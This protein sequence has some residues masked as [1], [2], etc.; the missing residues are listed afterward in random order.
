MNKITISIVILFLLGCDIYAQ[1]S[2]SSM[3]KAQPIPDRTVSYTISSPGVSKPIIWGLDLAWL[4]ETNIRRGIAF[5]GLNRVDVVRSSFMPTNPLLNGNTLQGD[6]LTNTTKRID[7]IKKYLGANASVVLNSDHPSVSSYF[8]GNATNWAK[9]IEVTAKLHEAEGMT[10]KT[11]SPFNEPDYSATGQGS[12]GDFYNICGQLRLNPYFNTIRISG[13]NT[14]N[15]DAAFNWYDSLKDRLDEGNTHQL[16]GSFNNYASF[17]QSV[18]SNN[19]HATND[20][21]HNVM[22]AMVGVEYGMQTGIWWGTAELARGEF[23]KASDGVRLGYAEHRPNWSAASVYKNL[24]GK[25]QLFGGTSERQAVTTTYRFVSKERDVYYDGYGP[26]REYTMVLPGGT[27]YQQGQTNAERMVNVSWGEDIQP[28]IDGQYVIVNRNSGKVLEVAGGSTASGANIQQGSYS[29]SNYQKWNVTPVSSRVGGDFSYFNVK[30]VNS[31]KSLDDLN[32]SLDDGGRLIQWDNSDS[33][34]QQRYLE[35]AN[36]G[37]FYIRSRHSAKCLD[38]FESSTADGANVVQW[39][40]NNGANQQWRLIPVGAAVEFVAPNAPTALVASANAESVRLDWATNTE[41]DLAG[42]TIFRAESVAGPY[43]TIA[44]NITSNSFVDN[45]T[46]IAGNY[47]Y[48]IKAVDKSLNSSGFSN[49]VSAV[50]TGVKDLVS[51]YQFDGNTADKSAN[52]N[53]SALFG[54]AVYADDLFGTK[55]IKLDGSTNFIQLPATLANQQE[56]TIATWVKWTGGASWQR[57][58]DFG[59]DSNEY[60]YLTPKSDSGQMRFGI[61]NGGS[62]QTLDAPSLATGAWS[63][64]AVTLGS[65]NVKIYVNGVLKSETNTISIRPLDFKPVLN[66]IGRGQFADPLFN[67]L[68]DAF[69]VYNYELSASEIAVL[70]E[71]PP[72]DPPVVVADAIIVSEG[73]AVTTL[74][75]G[76]NNLLTNDTDKENNTLT[77]MVVTNPVNGV[78]TLNANGTFTYVHNGTSTTSD[79]FTYKV[80]DGLRDSNVVTVNITIN[81]FSLP[82]DNFN[83]ETKSETCLGKNN[84]QIIVNATGS[85]SYTATINSVNYNFVNKNLTVSNLAPG[86]Y[87]LCIGISGK[88]FQQCYTLQIGQGGV[89]SGKSSLNNDKLEVEI[90]E[91]TAP[92]EVL[93]NSQSKFTST[94]SNFSVSV[95]EGDL[96]EVKTAKPCEGIYAKSV[97]GLVKNTVVGYPNPTSGSFDITIPSLKLDNVYAEIFSVDGKLISKGNYTIVNQKIQLDLIN[98]SEGVYLVKVYVDPVVSLTIIKKQ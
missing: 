56:I 80:N 41:T 43:N 95:N 35:Y 84:G 20:E 2:S 34:N 94:I 88:S 30:S 23:V 25:V 49:V 52:L 54:T 76:G 27:G 12:L 78:L 68:L 32:F 64:V 79:S 21:L 28:V 46:T 89:L 70:A 73:E 6:A 90:I 81:P 58:F 63:H 39:E 18:R 15:A 83:I 7:I 26:Q 13:G 96:V 51:F 19:D 92:F 85:Y 31:G 82:H 4:S 22:E 5:M 8:Y 74:V 62:E 47:Y 66:Y 67:G 44:R 91:G 60:L 9:L 37:W 1:M 45:T 16:A 29:G 38:V 72:N 93:V 87:T 42:Y 17:F 24:D 65:T 50:T 77:A 36:D 86:S 71:L 40:K 48:K 11:V 75:G 69:R 3:I 53:H 98:A 59:N 33:A 10:I 55:A 97:N 57:I 61:K 14:L